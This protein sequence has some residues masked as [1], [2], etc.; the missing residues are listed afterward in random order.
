VIPLPGAQRPP[1]PGRPLSQS[2]MGRKMPLLPGFLGPVSG[3]EGDRSLPAQ[4]SS[5]PLAA[6]EGGKR[7][8]LARYRASRS[9]AQGA[10]FN[11][12]GRAT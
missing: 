11:H 10:T 4:P 2:F 6:I 8:C 3:K 1:V 5:T 7:F 9:H 12:T